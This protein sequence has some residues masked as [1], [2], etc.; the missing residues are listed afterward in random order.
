MKNK[1]DKS[2]LLSLLWTISGI[3]WL[4][5]YL[6]YKASDLDEPKW[7]RWWGNRVDNLVDYAK[8]WIHCRAIPFTNLQ[9]NLS[10]IMKNRETYGRLL[11]PRLD[12]TGRK[13]CNCDPED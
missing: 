7:L 6:L 2:F 10:V 1:H 11:R 4:P 8:E 3:A 9:L 13:W 5:T 12:D